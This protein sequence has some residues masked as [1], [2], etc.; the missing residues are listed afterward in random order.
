MRWTMQRLP[1]VSVE[2]DTKK[3]GDWDIENDH[4]SLHVATSTDYSYSLHSRY[5]D[6]TVRPWKY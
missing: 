6:K 4:A 2:F 1:A 3:S 5:P